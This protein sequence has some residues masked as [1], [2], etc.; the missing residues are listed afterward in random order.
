MK[1]QIKLNEAQLRNIVA[2]SVKKV[3]KEIE[4]GSDIKQE[5]EEYV[6]AMGSQIEQWLCDYVFVDKHG[7]NGFIYDN[8]EEAK[9]SVL[10][11][12]EHQNAMDYVK[13]AQSPEDWIGYLVEGGV[14]ENQAINMVRN[15]DWNG[16]V[17]VIVDK[18]GPEWF[19]SQYS[20]QVHEL[21]NGQLLYF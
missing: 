16:I 17:N 13:D 10:N 4:D 1:K 3:L 19:L 2:E 8:E 5:V 14:D 7:C 21:T 12:E 11:G 18:E 20:G 15:E 6:H 9:Q